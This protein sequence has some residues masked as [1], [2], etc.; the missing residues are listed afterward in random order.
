VWDGN[1]LNRKLKMRK[2]GAQMILSRN[3]EVKEMKN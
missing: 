2:K 3:M 1:Y